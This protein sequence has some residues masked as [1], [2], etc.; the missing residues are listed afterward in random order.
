MGFLLTQSTRIKNLFRTGLSLLVY[1]EILGRQ[2]GHYVS[3]EILRRQ[4]A[5]EETF[6][7]E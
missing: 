3:M 7:L 6:Q 4:V 1:M 5:G 2:V